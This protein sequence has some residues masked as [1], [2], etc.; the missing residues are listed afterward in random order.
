MLRRFICVVLTTAVAFM[1]TSCAAPGRSS[2]QVAER[3][4][5]IELAR[6]LRDIA[7]VAATAFAGEVTN[8]RLAGADD[9]QTFAAEAIRNNAVAYIRSIALDDDPATALVDMYAFAQLGLWACENRTRLFSEI[10]IEDCNG[11]YGV[12]LDRTRHLAEQW[13][14][15]EQIAQIDEAVARFKQAEP[16]RTRIGI[17]RLP[18]LA[19]SSGTTTASLQTASP[20]LFSPVTEAAEQLEQTRL[21]G[22]RLLW[23]LSR[24]PETIGWTAQAAMA[25]VF[26]SDSV[27]GLFEL[28]STLATSVETLDAGLAETRSSLDTLAGSTDSMTESLDSLAETSDRLGASL[29]AIAPIAESLDRTTIGL[30]E[31]SRELDEF[32]EHAASVETALRSFSDTG[33]D[34]SASLQELS[35]RIVGLDESVSNLKQQILDLESLEVEFVDRLVWKIAGFAVGVV[36]FA[37]VIVALALRLGRR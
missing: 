32:D 30:G 37:G 11:T 4:Q 23:L 26:A 29:A 2:E 31:M 12:V 7:D 14:T 18:E 27:A 1:A 13:M 25:E 33:G 36:L 24:L 15:A 10:F 17:V 35:T 16:D 8:L 9:L 21:L 28:G 20:T 19:H 6:R 3:D 5:A 22:A 34:L